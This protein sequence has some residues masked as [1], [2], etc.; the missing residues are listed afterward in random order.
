MN[1]P[2]AALIIIGNEILSGRTQDT[3]TPW[4]GV[5]LAAHGVML[6]EVRVIPDDRDIIINTVNE[7]RAKFDNVLTTGGIGPTH[8]D[9]TAEAIAAAFGIDLVRNEDAVDMLVSHLKSQSQ[10]SPAR[11]KMCMI[12]EGATLIANPVSGAPGFTIE[13][14][15]V[16][17]GVPDIMH[18]MLDDVLATLPGGP[19]MLS[20][21]IL[22]TLTESAVADGLTALQDAHP[23][24]QIGSYPHFRA[25]KMGLS[26][27]LRGPDEKRL[28]QVSAALIALIKDL[29]GEPQSPET[30]AGGP[31]SPQ[32]PN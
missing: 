25:G 16:M 8:D 15:H 5:H 7:L 21:T 3:N 13:N 4:I 22:C 20:Q 2:T 1:G 31:Q 6:G 14:V 28:E 29:G 27:V 10:L 9:I 24:V 30:P 23:D 18:A 32:A 12:P 26:L 19:P 17:A 11:L